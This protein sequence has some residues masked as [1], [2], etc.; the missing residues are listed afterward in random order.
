MDVLIDVVD[1]GHRNE[2]MMLPVRR[3][4]FGQLDLVGA[5]QMVD[6]ADRFLVRRDDVHMFPDL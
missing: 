2:V 5:F 4:L 3:T 6:F 1:P